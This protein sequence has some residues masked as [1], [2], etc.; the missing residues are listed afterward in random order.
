[1]KITQISTRYWPYAAGLEEFLYSLSKELSANGND[2]NVLTTNSSGEF[3]IPQIRLGRLPLNRITSPF[4]SGT[5]RINDNFK[6]Q[7]LK[8]YVRF[9]PFHLTNVMKLT[10]Q[11]SDIV[12]V[13]ALTDFLFWL[14]AIG[15]LSDSKF[16]ITIHDVAPTVATDLEALFWKP[17]SQ[18]FVPKLI[19]RFQQ[20][21]VPSLTQIEYLENVGI[22]RKQISL[23]PL[24]FDPKIE[25]IAN[26]NENSIKSIRARYGVAPQEFLIISIGR[27]I[28][29]KRYDLVIYA[30]NQIFQEKPLEQIKYI[31]VGSDEGELATLKKLSQRLKLTKKIIFT[32]IKSHIETLQLLKS[33]DLFLMPS[34]IEAFNLATVEA[35]RLSIPV[36]ISSGVGVRYLIRQDKNGIIFK[37]NDIADLT[38]KLLKIIDDPSK[39]Q[40]MGIEGKKTAENV[41]SPKVVAEKHNELYRKSL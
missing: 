8:A 29:T 15:R 21:I 36:L 22:N 38:I 10:K 26:D 19:K 23:I 37:K 17:Y 27:L 13:H 2:I 39:Y 1:M 40:R 34:E 9:G 4:P 11:K 33:A 14:P 31:I 35:M 24:C 3:S 12:H 30:L 7:R 41:C 25:S 18:F 5:T 28:A 16:I 20:I 32:G 6:I